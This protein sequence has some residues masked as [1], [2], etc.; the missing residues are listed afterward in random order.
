MK[1]NKNSGNSMTAMKIPRCYYV[2]VIKA[3]LDYNDFSL[4]KYI[5][6]AHNQFKN[7]PTW[8][9]KTH[10]FRKLLKLSICILNGVLATDSLQRSFKFQPPRVHLNLI[11][12]TKI[13]HIL[14]F[15][16][17]HVLHTIEY[18]CKSSF[19]LPRPQFL[20]KHY[21]LHFWEKQKDNAASC[22]SRRLNECYLMRM[23][24]SDEED[25]KDD[26]GKCEL[27]TVWELEATFSLKNRALTYYTLL[28]HGKWV[29]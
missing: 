13:Q 7:S 29:L 19:I 20:Q 2:I 27:S 21:F 9:K 16:G 11:Q 12:F 17:F 4:K 18:T 28:P 5:A 25:H 6:T 24:H 3:I 22:I 1:N 15:S 8:G 14:N 23:I 26:N 10:N